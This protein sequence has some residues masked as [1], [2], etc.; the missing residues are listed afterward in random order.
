MAWFLF[1]M[2]IVYIAFGCSFILAPMETK[3]NMRLLTEKGDR[4]IWAAVAGIAG[5]LFL[6]SYTASSHP[7]IIILVGILA[8]IKG[9]V[10]FVNPGGIYEK[11]LQWYY[12]DLSAETYRIHGIAAL[13][14]GTVIFC[15]TI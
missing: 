4:R 1:F 8:L 15:W 5:V 3:E 13:I 14:L 11:T 2:S 7:W 6:F 12:G 10:F 9:G